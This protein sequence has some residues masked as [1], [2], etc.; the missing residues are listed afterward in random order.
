MT[1]PRLDC[2]VA[3]TRTG[4]VL[5]DLNGDSPSAILQ[6]LAATLPEILS[7]LEGGSLERVG[8]LLDPECPTEGFSEV[9]LLSTSYV[10]VIH[11]LAGRPSEALLANAPAGRSVG[12]VLSQVHARTAE[13]ERE[14]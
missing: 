8:A 14:P 1:S 13:L 7:S 4:V 6:D 9:L 12:L 3:S 5:H 10:H 2:V 11:P